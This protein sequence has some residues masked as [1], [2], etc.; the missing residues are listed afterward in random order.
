[1]FPVG[2]FDAFEFLFKNDCLKKPYFLYFSNWK[3]NNCIGF[4]Q[5][6]IVSSH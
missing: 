6:M 3:R 5:N 1:M 2:G 4:E